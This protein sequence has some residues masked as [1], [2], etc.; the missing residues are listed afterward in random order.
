MY[1]WE[2]KYW[3]GLNKPWVIVLISDKYIITPLN[4]MKD[5][6]GIGVWN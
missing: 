1:G 2:N 6:K 5:K 3:F 4:F